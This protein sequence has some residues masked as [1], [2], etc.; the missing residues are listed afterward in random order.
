MKKR[1]CR[2][3]ILAVTGL[4][5]CAAAHA[6]APQWDSYAIKFA[7]GNVF[8]E[9]NSALG[10]NGKYLTSINIHNPHYLEDTLVEGSVGGISIPVIF[11]KKVVLSQPQGVTPLPPSCHILEALSADFALGVNC[12]NIKAQLALSGLPSTGPQEGFVVLQVPPL[13]GL[14]DSDPPELDVT[15]LY[16]GRFTGQPANPT[17][18]LNTWDVEQ[19]DPRALRGDP[20]INECAE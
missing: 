16:T 7:C 4:M 5:L 20:V 9:A 10:V 19:I 15:A 18:G 1:A 14:D 8:S 2:C 3:L 12:A 13:Q 17:N 11:Y 6:G